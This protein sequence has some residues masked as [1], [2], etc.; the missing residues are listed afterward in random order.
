MHEGSFSSVASRAHEILLAGALDHL[1]TYLQTGCQR[2][3]AY[4][5]LL[6]KR[7]DETDA[8]SR[9]LRHCYQALAEA[10]SVSPPISG[11]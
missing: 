8:G 10:L 7:L 4:A 3:A 1:S 11:R 5:R 9:E 2:S 6:L